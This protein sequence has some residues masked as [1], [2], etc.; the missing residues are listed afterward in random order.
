MTG[1]GLRRINAGRGHYYRI[2]GA[3]V[4]AVTELLKLG[5]PPNLGPWAARTVAEFVADHPDDI[6]LMRALPRSKMINDLGDEPFRRA[7]RAAVRGTRIHAL[8]RRLHNGE[9]IEVPADLAGHVRSCVEYL[10][11]WRPVP[12]LS[13]TVIGSRTHSYGGTFDDFSWFPGGHGR[14]LVEYKSGRDVHPD[15]ALQLAAYNNADCWL[16]GG[17]ERV[18][19]PMPVDGALVVHLGEDGYEVH[20]VAH[21]RSVFD[22]FL[23]V[24]ATARARRDLAPHWLSTPLL[25]PLP[26]PTEA[27]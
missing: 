18:W 19:P 7:R 10:D 1:A 24:A 14:C 16:D 12:I 17:Q 13:E 25:A 23:T 11:E 2:D 27:P 4:D 9:K 5:A 3:K 6:T 21:D 26:E 22:A 20:R 8:A 15:V